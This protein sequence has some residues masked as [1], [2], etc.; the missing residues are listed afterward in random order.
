MRTQRRPC[1]I[2]LLKLRNV[3]FKLRNVSF[4]LRNV[5]FKLRN[6]SFDAISCKCR[7]DRTGRGALILG[8]TGSRLGYYDINRIIMILIEMK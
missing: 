4:K 2:R 6:V 1:K 7:V 5:S 8:C 3:S